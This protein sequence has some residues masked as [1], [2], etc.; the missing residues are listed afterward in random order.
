MDTSDTGAFG[1]QE[2]LYQQALQFIDQ[3]SS[4]L[5]HHPVTKHGY[6]RDFSNGPSE[7]AW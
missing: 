5:D 7:D 1:K 2:L 6:L 3:E 4:K